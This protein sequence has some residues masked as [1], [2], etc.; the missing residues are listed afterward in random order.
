M[1]APEFPKV[2]SLSTLRN[3]LIPLVRWA[4]RP[5]AEADLES[6]FGH[7][8]NW[9][10]AFKHIAAF[11]RADFSCLPSARLLPANDMPGLLGGYSR[12]TREI[13]ISADCPQELL[14][15]VLI[16]EIGHF[17]DQE[18]CSEETPG[19]EGAR[20]A[21]LV[22]G[23]PLEA[24]SSDD[25][26]APIS[27][28]GRQILVEA[29]RKARG[30]GKSKAK[31]R[32]RKIRGSSSSSDQV[33]GGGSANPGGSDNPRLESNIFYATE[34]N[35][36]ITQ[37]APGDRLIGSSGNDTFVV[38]SQNVTIEDPYDGTDTV[39]SSVTFSLAN[40]STIEN[41]VLTGASNIDGTGNARA[42]VIS[43]NSGNNKLDGGLGADT[44]Q[45]GAGNDTLLGGEGT[46]L[47]EGGEG[48]DTYYVESSLEGITE[49]AGGGVDTIITSDRSITLL[50][51]ANI[52]NII[53]T[54]ASGGG[55]GGG[56]GGGELISTLGTDNDDYLFGGAGNDT[57]IGKAGN[58]TLE[59]RVGD[60]S[61]DGGTGSDTMS[62]GAGNDTYIVDSMTDVIQENVNQGTDVVISSISYT[63]TDNVENL[64][65]SPTLAVA[66]ANIDGTGNSLAN[67]ITGNNGNNQLDGGAGS[68]TLLGGA[69][70]DIL[71]GGT[72]D[73]R[74]LGGS[75]NDT[76]IVDSALDTIIDS[77]GTDVVRASVSFDIG[78]PDKVSGIEHLVYTGAIKATLAGNA[79]DNSLTVLQENLSN[80]D[81][82]VGGAGDDTLSAGLGANSLVGGDGDDYYIIN[83]NNDIVAEENSALG[84]IDTVISKVS[85]FSLG[86]G[87]NVEYLSYEGTSKATL[88]GSGS[89]N[90]ISGGKYGNF[91]DALG[92][93]DS[94]TGGSGADT[95]YGGDGNDTLDGKGGS[96]ILRGGAGNDVYF[97]YS[98][99][100]DIADDGDNATSKDT[101]YSS[102]TFSLESSNNLSNIEGLQLTG[103]SNASGTGNL[104]A[105]SLF[106][107]DGKNS[108]SGKTGKDTIFGGLGSDTI[109]G[110]EGDDFIVGGGS[111]QGD[112]KAD[113]TTPVTIGI[114]QSFSGTFDKIGDGILLNNFDSD[115]IRA[116]LKA[117][118][119]YVFTLEVVPSGIPAATKITD[120]GLGYPEGPVDKGLDAVY[121]VSNRYKT[122]TI[123]AFSDTEVYVP[124][125]SDGPGL[126]TYKLTLNGPGVPL[127]TDQI[128]AD[129]ASNTLIGGDGRD[130]LISG[131]GRDKDRNPIGDL[132]LGGTNGMLGSVDTD[133]SGD[134]LIGGDGSDTLDGGSEGV[135]SYN[136]LAGGNGNDFYYLRSANDKVLEL[137][138]QGDADAM[139]I[140]FSKTTGAQWD[141]DL[142]PNGNYANIELVTLTGAAAISVLGN[143]ND[144]QIVGNFG[145]NTID[146]GRGDD[147][148][149]GGGGNDSLIGGKGA[150]SLDGGSG[151]NTL[152]GGF[153]S[154]TY[155]VNDRNDRIIN[156]IDGLDGGIDLVRTYFNFDPLQGLDENGKN[157]FA[158]N[159]AD[160]SPSITKAPSFAS[161]DLASFYNLN[162]F[163]LLGEAVYGV[164][165]ALAN[166]I[167]A[168]SSSALLLGNGGED[169]LMGA[170]GADS[171][172]GDTPDFY[173]TPDLYAAAAKDTM[174]KEFLL[175]VI[176]KDADRDYAYTTT[177]AKDYLDGGEGDDYLDGGRG[178]DT[179]I[180]GKGNDTFV[181]DNVN[182]YI[183]AGD[184]ANELISSVNIEQ[185]PDG[186]SKLM[187]VVAKQ[188][189]DSGQS[190]VASFGSFL[191]TKNGNN[192]SEN[193]NIGK[194]AVTVK[195]VNT[196]ELM[197]APREGEV[198][199]D[200]SL[201]K[202]PQEA[203]LAN[204]GKFQYDLSWKASVN[205]GTDVVGYVVKYKRTDITGDIWHTYVN[206][207]SQDFQGSPTAPILTVTNLDS[208]T[209]DFQVTAIERTIPALQD[210]SAAQHVTLEGGA[211]NDVVFGTRI[212]RGLPGAQGFGLGDALTD[213]LIQNNP[214]FGAPLGFIFNPAPY[215]PKYSFPNRFASY[216][217]GGYGNDF[218]LG[219][220]INDLS[221]DDYVFQGVTFKGLNTLVGGQGSDTFA[222]LNGG[223]AIGDEFDWV[224]KYGNETPVV[225]QTDNVG[226]SLNGGQHNLVISN[227]AYL[228][229][230]DDLVSQGKFIDQLALAGSGQ[231]GQG[232]RLDNYIYDA[233]KGNTLVGDKGR[234]SIVGAGG[235][236]IGGTAYGIDQVG[237]AVKDFAAVSDGGNGLIN[238]IF[239]DTDPVPVSPNGPG[240]ADPSQ[241]WFVPGYY[242]AAYDPN[243]NSDTLVANGP[244]ALDGGAGRDSLVGSQKTEQSTG[245]DMFY[246]SAGEGGADS[247]KIEFGDAVFGAVSGNKG[248]DTI[249]FTD[250]DYLWW[251]GHLQGAVL[252]QHS[253]SIERGPSDGASDISNLILQDGAA[254]ARYAIGNDDSTG[255]LGSSPN[256]QGSNWIVGNE[257]DN[258]LDGGGVGG[259]L[260][261]GV[262][263]DTLKGGS[264]NDVFIV[265]G[266]T[267]SDANKWSPS[268]LRFL[269]T[270]RTIE[271]TRWIK[272]DSIY[273]DGDYVK[274]LD[275]EAGD[276]L[277]LSGPASNY[278]IGA[279]ATILPT[280][281]TPNNITPLGYL[282]KP[283][284]TCFGIYT[285]GTP[286]LVAVVSLVGGL[287]LDT[288]TLQEAF[289]PIRG[290]SIRGN[291]D[292]AEAAKLGWG[293]F[294]KL[295]GSSFASY[296]NQAYVKED[297]FA[298]LTTLVRSGD[299]T[300]IGSASADFYNGYGGNDSLLGG[301]NSDTLL[302]GAG[303]DSLLGQAGNDSLLGEAGADYIDGGT[304]TDQMIGGTGDDTFVVNVLGDMVSEQSNEGTDLV[305]ASVSGYALTANVENLTLTGTAISGTGNILDN[306]LTGN[307]SNN[308]LAGLSGKDTL[309]GGAGTDTLQGGA[310]DDTYIVD[311]TNDTIEDTSGTDIVRT[312]A[313]FDLSASKVAGG[314]DIEH[315]LYTGTTTGVS[316]TGN[317]NAN[318]VTGAAGS[319]TLNGKEGT[320]TLIGGV[321]D[322]FYVYTS[323][324]ASGID[325]IVDSEGTDAILT[326][327]H[328]DLAATSLNTSILGLAN[329][330]NLQLTSA[331]GASLLGNALDNSITGN[332]GND[333][334]EGRSSSGTLSGDTL[335]GSGGDDLYIVDSTTDLI[336]DSSGTDTILTSVSF[337]LSNSL[338]GGGSAIENLTFTRDSGSTLVGNAAANSIRG[339]GG[340][341]A[342]L[343]IG[344][345]GNDTYFVGINDVVQEESLNGGTDLVVSSATYALGDFIEN[346]LLDGTA[347]IHGTGNSL[348]NSIIGNS[349]ANS[350]DGGAGNATLITNDTFI[351]N[352]GNDTYIVDNGNDV[353]IESN[354]NSLIGGIDLVEASADYALTDNV[355][356]LRLAG[357]VVSG[358]GN[359]LANSLIGNS[360]G[361]YLDGGAGVDTFIGGKGDDTY[362]LDTSGETIVE[363]ASEGTDLVIVSGGGYS[364]GDNIENLRLS[365]T[366]TF[367][368]GNELDNSIT[369]NSFANSLD[370][371]SGF[372]TL[373]GG[374]GD[375]TYVVD[376]TTDLIIDSNGAS[377]MVRSSVSFDLSDTLVGDGTAIEHLV[378][379][380]SAPS[381]LLGN[382]KN[383][384]ITGG[385]G[386]DS[387]V[388]N[389]GNDTF[390]G[391]DGSDTYLVDSIGDLVLEA[392]SLAGGGTDLVVASVSYTIAADSYVE[393]LELTGSAIFG[394]GNSI[395]NTIT[396]NVLSNSLDGGAGIDSLIGGEGDDTYIVDD[397]NDKLSETDADSLTGGIDLVLASVSYALGANFEKLTLTGTSAISGTGN[398]LSNTITGNSGANS[399]DGGTGIDSLVGGAGND[400]Y[401]VDNAADV[402]VEN[403]SEG[404]DLVVSSL[405]YTLSG[406][407]EN[408]TLTGTDTISGTGNSLSNTLAGNASANTLDGGSGADSLFGGSGADILLGG[409]GEDTLNA[410][411]DS[412]TDTLIGGADSDAYFVDSTSDLLVEASGGG[413]ADTVYSST[414]YALGSN[415]E[416][417][418]LG[419]G[420]F[421]PALNGGVGGYSDTSSLSG[422]GNSAA[423]SLIGNAGDNALDGL[424][425]N[426][427]M[428]GGAGNDTYYVAE[429]GDWVI[430]SLAG[431][432]NFVIKAVGLASYHLE[433]VASGTVTEITHAVLNLTGGNDIV[434]SNTP[435]NFSTPLND[436]IYGLGGDDSILGGKGSDILDGGTGSDTLLG[437]SGID[438]LFGGDGGDSLLGGDGIDSLV[439]GTGNDTYVIDI[440]SKDNVYEDSLAAGGTADLIQVNGS[441]SIADPAPLPI[442]V[443]APGPYAGIEGL[444]YTGL[445]GVT[446]IGNKLAN[447]I[448]SGDGSDSIDGGAGADTLIG[449]KGND[450]YIYTDG[451]SIVESLSEGTDEVRSGLDVDLSAMQNLENIVLTGSLGVGAT[452]NAG[453]NSIL[454]NAASNALSGGDGND[455]LVGLDGADILAGGAGANSLVGGAGNDTYVL[456]AAANPDGSVTIQDTLVEVAN[457]GT[458]EIRVAAS[459]D[460]SQLPD[461]E[462]VVLQGTGNFD[463][464][465]NAS[466]NKITG[467][468]GANSLD[469]GTGA[470]TLIGKN[471][472]DTYIVDNV[473]DVVQEISGGGTD[474]VV[475]SLQSYTLSG[476]LENLLLIAGAG[477]SG[478]GNTDPNQ[479]TGSAGANSLFGDQGNDTILAGLGDDYIEGGWNTDSLVGGLGDDTYVIEGGRDVVVEGATTD[480]DTLI[481]RS[482]VS[483]VVS[484]TGTAAV[485]F[486]EVQT[487][488]FD[489]PKGTL[490]GGGAE[491]FLDFDTLHYG[492]LNYQPYTSPLLL[493]GGIVSKNPNYFY[494]L[495]ENIEKLIVE[496]QFIPINGLVYAE[497]SNQPD[498]VYGNAL[499][500]YIAV[501]GE[502]LQGNGVLIA[503][504]NYIDGQGGADTMAGGRG[505]DFYIVDNAGDFVLESSGQGTD[506]VRAS[507]THTLSGNVEALELATVTESIVS[508]RPVTATLAGAALDFHGYGSSGDNSIF[509][510]AGN[511]SLLGLAGNDYLVGGDGAD[512]MIGGKGNDTYFVADASDWV[513]ETEATGGGMNYIYVE[514][515]ATSFH[516]LTGGDATLKVVL[517]GESYGTEFSDTLIGNPLRDTIYGLGGDDFIYGLAG[518]DS[519]LGG[520]GND[521]IS[522]GDGMDTLIG[523][524]GNDT[525]LGDA[526]NNSLFGGAGNDSLVS[527][528][529]G[530]DTLIGGAGNDT[531][532][533][534]T[535]LNSSIDGGA[536]TDL[537][538]FVGASASLNNAVLT[539]IEA[540]SFSQL[541][542]NAAIN[543]GGNSTGLTTI[544]GGVGSDSI[545]LNSGFGTRAITLDGG[546]GGDRF[547]FDSLPQMK[548]ASL[549]GGNGDDTLAFSNGSTTI[550]DSD[551]TSIL[552]SKLEVLEFSATGNGAT[553]GAN[554]QSSGI[555]TVV[556][557]TNNDTINASNYTIDIT[558]DVSRNT[559]ADIGGNDSTVLGG[560]GN[561][562][563]IFSNHN[564]LGNSSV[565]GGLGNDTLAFSEDGI[566]I[567]EERFNTR[568]VGFE[569]IQTKNGTNY[570]NLGTNAASSGL[571]SLFGGTGSDT[572]DVNAFDGSKLSIDSGDGANFITVTSFTGSTL[573]IDSGN[574]ADF[575]TA[576]AFSGSL[577][578]ID[579]GDGADTITGS[580]TAANSILSGDGNN[581][582]TLADAAAVGRSTVTGGIDTDTLS[583]SGNTI[584]TDAQLANV[585][586]V[587]ILRAAV[588]G[589]SSLT[590]GANAQAGGILTV[591]GG[592]ANDTLNAAAFTTG[593]TLSGGVGNDS[594]VVSTG[595]I[596]GQSSIAGGA[597]TDTLSFSIDQLS[598]TDADFVNATSVEFLKTAN[599]NNRVVLGANAQAAFILTLEG[600]TGNDT[601]NASAYT[602]GMT[603]S[604]GTGND[605]LLTGTGNDWISGTSTVSFGANQ[606][607]TLT[608]GTGNDTFIL[609]DVTN[610]YY[611]TA[612][613]GADYALI[614][615]FSTGDK[616][617]LKNLNPAA[618][619]NGYL[620]GSAAVPAEVLY[621]ALGS[622][623]YYLY[624]DSNNNGTLESG[625]NLIA[626]IQTTGGLALTT[627]NLKSTHG[628]FV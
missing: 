25:S 185:A 484:S 458:D 523:D 462:N 495:P 453:D 110:D 519:L 309:D 509:G 215:E 469:G 119:E 543:L 38:L 624:R 536:N 612:A 613:N 37:K 425:G 1:F 133:Q 366:A 7:R 202:G 76:Y 448:T 537:L 463:V 574:D 46:D 270:D 415:V 157:S 342:D 551:F 303:N 3:F 316:L 103:N 212:V 421:D 32:G 575:I 262:G 166:S 546:D 328:F 77:E 445:S 127:A 418:Y 522:G 10:T 599:G 434:S 413:T 483:A 158:P 395:A 175:K 500:N 40:H 441:F 401:F 305:L 98:Q 380:G 367:G 314:T 184:G 582:I 490:V 75:G 461:F 214:N 112:L 456:D 126:G 370:G 595:A 177:Y 541:A 491:I 443:P 170:A 476:N 17:L 294:W 473:G 11:R 255:N 616:F 181:Q 502:D 324:V 19:E 326:A 628:S 625:D 296:V 396:G 417:I 437:E 471:G 192:R 144:N 245:A 431:E 69:G 64:T 412:D 438:T 140:G 554:A 102:Q 513:V 424:G 213:P 545:S 373:V 73:D 8:L 186:I 218:L 285:A 41:L 348:A 71:S 9:A 57:I 289:T 116:E 45:G 478:Y 233:D 600:G 155:I 15:A 276:N 517:Q 581:S 384:S 220:F 470:D 607:D 468:D 455:T 375:D 232:N 457:G 160:F 229:L 485:V 486:P 529:T 146:G 271:E 386:A 284:S 404:T 547:A 339:G 171:L 66:D 524:D 234:D 333:T 377:D 124:I 539:N 12:D 5:S 231:F 174:T 227:V 190:E 173:A 397:V 555:T 253:Y 369:G 219:D 79:G 615:D 226:S 363:K 200:G 372:D 474:L 439:G 88:A 561:D 319:D 609:G 577:L 526:G 336:Q 440:A 391:N 194:I 603:L 318:S 96:D 572:I 230:S 282:D 183:V 408:L 130:T 583:L 137:S 95:I 301:D 506:S 449:G 530:I 292:A 58:D 201:T 341:G 180:G 429:T 349:G 179:M 101:V 521:S 622:S 286:N 287:A 74:L 337:D 317:I 168:G 405:S 351:G 225:T 150:D 601:L 411:G 106:G 295:D 277:V 143:E 244:S 364:L 50:T 204:L 197:Y 362:V 426:D 172:F 59:G 422:F 322:D 26:L 189:A 510:N 188:S 132:L 205:A 224:V 477:S 550:V 223:N 587:E 544:T 344:G 125:Y 585:S 49:A 4:S 107:N 56:G 30:S 338:V 243:R 516:T 139:Y 465:G 355:E 567:T 548:A 43:G 332:A 141:I 626:G 161:R 99:S 67:L 148:L 552:S 154:D 203:D 385:A 343:M 488:T 560:S 528:A 597:G 423:N 115:W 280:D 82:L 447:T 566:S 505:N 489:L 563:V 169:T 16:E 121:R 542:G 420:S 352:D 83:S 578:S 479:I 617:Q 557:G 265:K 454:G 313:S 610:A 252:E 409:A 323:S 207:K 452:G 237:L 54:G 109:S 618:I 145:N 531:L 533:V 568:F 236:L 162:Y 350:L 87:S 388:G 68:D 264:G 376:T 487:I 93:N 63:L 520:S 329:I 606:I 621:G 120:Y 346:L 330:E 193:L 493:Q 251:S 85:N 586:G 611:N 605:S 117:G 515:D 565:L 24:A 100:Q 340:I 65:L 497:S 591:I 304:G 47:L 221:G 129:D 534:G 35:A 406:A 435:I 400:T 216:L 499:A 538:S 86:G 206:G 315:L 627:A 222:V 249:T 260:G 259:F 379:T 480:I 163:E 256:E 272:K 620:I 602:T 191:G 39:E 444:I 55:G 432:S 556:G 335:S 451:D 357:T 481:I 22:L 21:A 297:S 235:V 414:D 442:G 135:G 353:V 392:N 398:N 359:I 283:S 459:V 562:L 267:A 518:N 302:G 257:F 460:L 241:F 131:N 6:I 239:R 584:L 258:T 14:S 508:G 261:L 354:S 383:N 153:G 532:V 176:G 60:D 436:T 142:A 378:Y 371:G 570:V 608:G 446:L 298:S 514:D 44:L 138:D 159:L 498:Y 290:D 72:D 152:D 149:L 208:G 467:N 525:L 399:L 182:D 52:E 527:S 279:P 540:V 118:G 13:Y 299:D 136:S 553:L 123:T 360:V 428:I 91:I 28:Q 576:A 394:I 274:I 381:T 97:A 89:N 211:G 549:F 389:G 365:G 559:V 361:N 111:P 114:G 393:K 464:I 293:T 569:A 147:T 113:R 604:G 589:A 31:T 167:T 321:G 246:V 390:I 178:F 29:A 61:L 387:I 269:S 619:G 623:N 210:R 382:A 263:I 198:F 281:K 430:E 504:D 410:T 580:S 80:D 512:T 238:S 209:Y 20:F 122:L 70:N 18:L 496:N 240:T 306:R 588:S 78:K 156:E 535:S 475:S 34:T 356:N 53:Y 466:A 331:S 104:L 254:S 291:E 482:L 416:H 427:T 507:V 511:N 300:F 374:S 84:G 419:S 266:Y 327:T 196:L 105:N 310:D 334:L 579:S 598:V 312:S 247:D 36:R 614:T 2:L 23:L 165:N 217:D 308:T 558:I 108:L 288:L 345:K 573:S 347:N 273:A 92:G 564:V 590:V 268:Y 228:T 42:N 402:V 81:T 90:F 311:N 592:N 494:V 596:L 450:T 248:N 307:A 407:L 242:G 275:F 320:D 128:L 278:W 151:I 195:E 594:L 492:E 501:T 187:L 62:G 27:F 199:I 358:T 593:M 134:T 94:I 51:Y 368:G 48:D 403:S 164:G 472:D 571:V 503:F 250:S 433:T 33:G 325:V